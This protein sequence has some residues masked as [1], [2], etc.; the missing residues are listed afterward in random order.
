MILNDHLSC[1]KI[2]F[3]A[4]MNYNAC[5]KL[6]FL[7]LFHFAFLISCQYLI[8]FSL[9]QRR[10][11]L[12]PLAKFGQRAGFSWPAKIF[13]IKVFFQNGTSRRQN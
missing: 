11:N 12:G 5:L 2:L 4:K 7:N 8:F 3:T 6:V 10:Q 13:M 9:G 1:G